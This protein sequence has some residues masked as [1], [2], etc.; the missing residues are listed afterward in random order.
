MFDIFSLGKIL[1]LKVTFSYLIFLAFCGMFLSNVLTKSLLH[2]SILHAEILFVTFTFS[3]R[4]GE[5][6]SLE[7]LFELKSR[8]LTNRYWNI[9]IVHYKQNFKAQ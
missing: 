4:Y 5:I 8:I 2:Y 9:S 1:F 6:F 7:I 3:M